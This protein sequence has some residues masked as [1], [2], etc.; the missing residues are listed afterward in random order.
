MDRDIEIAGYLGVLFLGVILQKLGLVHGELTRVLGRMLIRFIYPA[1]IFTS[2][3]KN[4]TSSSLIGLW[5]L[6]IGAFLIMAGGATLGSFISRL[7]SFSTPR[8]QRTFQ[9]HCTMSNYAYLPLAIAKY[10]WGEK[11]MSYV[12]LSTV[13]SEIALWALAVPALRKGASTI[14]GIISPPIIALFFSIAFV[15]ADRKITNGTF[16]NLHYF[17]G[18]VGLG[19]IPVAM[20]ILGCHLG[21]TTSGRFS[22]IHFHLLTH[23]LLLVPIL[24]LTALQLVHLPSSVEKTILLLGIMPSSIIAVVVSELF[25]GDPD[26]AAKHVLYSHVISLISIPLWLQILI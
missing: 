22:R 7:T 20:F 15:L 14:S 24:T 13:G 3:T 21:K 18:K 4:F 5:S 25:G 8:E 1:L 19:A 11:G 6:P 16:A 26:L 10:L 9:F 12:I 23:R 2:I 17:L